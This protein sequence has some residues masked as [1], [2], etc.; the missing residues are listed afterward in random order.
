MSKKNENHKAI[1]ELRVMQ[2]AYCE[3]IR[4]YLKTMGFYASE[5]PVNEDDLKNGIIFRTTPITTK[6]WMRISHYA[7]ELLCEK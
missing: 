2:Y 3:R 6:D 7:Y 5:R 4:L 1:H